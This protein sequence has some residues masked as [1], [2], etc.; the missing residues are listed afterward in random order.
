MLACGLLYYGVTVN[1]IRGCIMAKKV[2]LNEIA[3]RALSTSREYG[4][5]VGLFSTAAFL[6][7]V[8]AKATREKGTFRLS[9]G[10]FL[11]V[12]Q[13][14]TGRGETVRVFAPDGKEKARVFFSSNRFRF[15]NMISFGAPMRRK[16]EEKG[17]SLNSLNEYYT[18]KGTYI[19]TPDYETVFPFI[20]KVIDEG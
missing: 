17:F 6:A 7:A 3:G 13:N 14:T 1:Y 19:F 16:M 12:A 20:K 2:T 10:S 8:D 15:A 11:T 4:R 18:H 9:G 5:E